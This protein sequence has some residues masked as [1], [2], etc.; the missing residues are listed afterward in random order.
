MGSSFKRIDVATKTKTRVVNAFAQAASAG[1]AGA[2]A[3]TSSSDEKCCFPSTKPRALSKQRTF[4]NFMGKSGGQTG[5]LQ[6]AIDVAQLNNLP[7][8]EEA[9]GSPCGPGLTTPPADRGG[10]SLKVRPSPRTVAS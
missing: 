4:G 6:D 9:V 10:K 8:G 5:S 2:S 3:A 1:A 7:E